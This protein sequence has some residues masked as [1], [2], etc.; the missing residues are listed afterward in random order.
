MFLTPN[1]QNRPSVFACGGWN[2]VSLFRISLVRGRKTLTEQT[3]GRSRKLVKMY[4]L[5]ASK[6]V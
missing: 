2:L 1:P 6:S 3:E 5:V 4:T